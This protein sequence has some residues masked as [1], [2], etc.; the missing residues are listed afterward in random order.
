MATHP[1]SKFSNRSDSMYKQFYVFTLKSFQPS[2]LY[3][4]LTTPLHLPSVWG[5]TPLLLKPRNVKGPPRKKLSFNIIS[6]L[7]C[8][9]LTTPAAN[10]N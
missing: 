8:N 2:L 7:G 10:D 4:T 9:G 1:V 5:P 3:I 6:L